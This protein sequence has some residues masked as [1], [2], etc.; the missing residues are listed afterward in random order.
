MTSH[1]EKITDELGQIK[2]S[3]ERL[4]TKPLTYIPAVTAFPSSPNTYDRVFRRDR[5]ME[6]FHDGTRWLSVGWEQIKIANT[7]NSLSTNGEYLDEVNFDCYNGLYVLEGTGYCWTPSNTDGS[8]YWRIEW[9]RGGGNVMGFENL[10]SPSA[11]Y[12]LFKTLNYVNNDDYIA[13]AGVKIGSPNSLYCSSFTIYYRE[14][15]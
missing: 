9:R 3:I 15:G 10:T 6:Y 1:F 13:V 4:E 5:G 2:R 12:E 14:I 7:N 8:N 11:N